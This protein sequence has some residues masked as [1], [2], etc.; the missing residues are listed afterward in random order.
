MILDFLFKVNTKTNEELR[1]KC[2][3]LAIKSL[4][5]NN[6]TGEGHIEERAD[7]MY[8]WI[9]KEDKKEEKK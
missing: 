4:E 2:L 9:I 3:E 8:N 1:L 5:K 7:F 6:I